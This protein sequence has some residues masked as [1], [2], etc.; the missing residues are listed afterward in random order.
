MSADIRDYLIERFRGD[1]NTLRQ[2][3]AAL[4]GVKKPAPGPDAAVSSAM[5]AACDDVATLS[6]QLPVNAPLDEIVRALQAMLPELVK[7]VNEPASAVSPAVRSVYAGACTRVQELITAETSALAGGSAGE[8]DDD[9]D[10][11]M[12]AQLDPF[13][14]DDPDA[15]D[16][17]EDDPDADDDDLLE[18][19][20][21]GTR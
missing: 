18:D 1:A 11:L 13:D 10:D 6:E 16:S 19:H 20:D 4:V 14:A 5:A 7:R 21:D 9:D 2:R 12:D 3:A 8:D 17:D 15:D